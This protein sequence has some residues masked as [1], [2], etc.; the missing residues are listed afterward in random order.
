MHDFVCNDK[1]TSH[2][3]VLNL[4]ALIIATLLLLFRRTSGAGIS[5]DTLNSGGNVTDGETLV[6]AGGTFTL[7]FFSPSTTVLTKRYLGIW[8]TASGTDAV[9]WV[10]NRETPLKTTPG[11]LVMSSR[12]GLRLLDGSGRTAWSSNTTGASASSVAQLLGS[13]NLVACARRAAAPSSS[14][15]R[16]TIRRTP[17][18]PA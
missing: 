15:S 3:A 11:V 12:M 14:G 7:G 1:H 4:L 5:P 16:S 8:F 17:C 6:S 10:A 9:L 2:M 18:S 13:G